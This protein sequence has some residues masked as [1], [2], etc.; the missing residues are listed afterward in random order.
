[1][2]TNTIQR[3]HQHRHQ[4]AIG[5]QQDQ[6]TNNGRRDNHDA[7]HAGQAVNHIASTVERAGSRGVEFIR[8]RPESTTQRR[9]DVIGLLAITLDR[10]LLRLLHLLRNP[11]IQQ[12]LPAADHLCRDFFIHRAWRDGFHLV[13]LLA[14][15]IQRKLCGG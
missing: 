4:I 11:L 1:M 8:R 10:S 13:E 7:R 15:I 3:F 9:C 5:E 6:Q 12:C 14:H 2:L